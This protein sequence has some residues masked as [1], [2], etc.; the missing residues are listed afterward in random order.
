MA[1]HWAFPV[2]GME[3]GGIKVWGL[4]EMMVMMAWTEE[5]AAAQHNM[6]YLL[7]KVLYG[8]LLEKN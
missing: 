7:E 4:E 8:I 5:V 2:N 6:L 3:N 1:V